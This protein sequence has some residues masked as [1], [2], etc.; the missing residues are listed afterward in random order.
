MKSVKSA[1]FV[2]LQI[3]LFT[4]SCA[5]EP[6]SKKLMND[7]AK[8]K[9]L[10]VSG[11]R[12]L[13]G[14]QR[15][16]RSSSSKDLYLGTCTEEDYEEWFTNEYPIECQELLGNASTLHML[17]GVYCDPFCGGIYFDYLDD[18]GSTGMVL[19]SFYT[20]LCIE[21]ERGVPCYYYITSDEHYNP[22]P[23]VDEYCFPYNESCSTKCYYALESMSVK[24]GCCVNT[25]YNQSIPDP[26]AQYVLWESCDL[27]APGRCQTGMELSGSQCLG[28]S[29][30]IFSIALVLLG[31]VI[32]K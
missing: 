19:S 4:A 13:T 20:H 26:V 30:N 8:L 12:E 32:F 1:C 23:E 22:R 31:G 18:C 16:A 27:T 9:N 10:A 29:L 24:L 7:L 25:L 6:R 5:A 21:N 3:A 17:F 14:D 28:N 11:T 15:V 2:L